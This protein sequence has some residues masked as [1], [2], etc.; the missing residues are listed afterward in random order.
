[1]RTSSEKLLDDLFNLQ[2]Q[3]DEMEV[4]DKYDLAQ[5][6]IMYNQL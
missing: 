5:A 3:K 4:A 6:K 2:S 1:M